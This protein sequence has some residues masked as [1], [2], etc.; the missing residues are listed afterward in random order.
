MYLSSGYLVRFW[1]MGASF[2]DALK[3]TSSSLAHIPCGHL[4]ESLELF[5]SKQTSTPSLS[6]AEC[7]LS[8]LNMCS[9]HTSCEHTYCAHFTRTTAFQTA[10]GL[11][12]FGPTWHSQYW[13]CADFS[14]K[15]S[16]GKVVLAMWSIFAAIALCFFTNLSHGLYFHMGETEKKCFI[17]E[18][19]DETM[20]IGEWSI[21]L[22]SI[23]P[24]LWCIA[25]VVKLLL[26]YLIVV[27]HP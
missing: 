2:L 11:T 1:G 13:A 12:R 10:R 16:A 27:L 22:L 15:R 23:V 17:E 8:S 20:V 21:Q 19:P 3:N 9:V 5:S 14:K 25:C 4:G 7:M 6:V 18:I 24:S 26:Q